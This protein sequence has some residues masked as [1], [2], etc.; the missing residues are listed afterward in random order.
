MQTIEHKPAFGRRVIVIRQSG[1]RRVA[2]RAYKPDAFFRNPN[3]LHWLSDDDKFVDVKFDPI[4]AW[5]PLEEI[6]MKDHNCEI[7]GAALDPILP[8]LTLC[9]R[10]LE[11]HD[12]LLPLTHN[13]KAR[14]ALIGELMTPSMVAAI[15]D[16]DSAYG[17]GEANEYDV[18]QEEGWAQ[19]AN[20]ARRVYSKKMEEI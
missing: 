20:V 6:D 1:D 8:L 19:L 16:I 10:C 3:V 2:R 15:V 4:I 7:C 14:L 12:L 13:E 5:M 18:A 11:L 9:R 17:Y